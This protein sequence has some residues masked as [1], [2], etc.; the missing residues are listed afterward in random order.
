MPSHQVITLYKLILKEKK[1]LHSVR[2]GNKIWVLEPN[3]FKG[4]T[5]VAIFNLEAQR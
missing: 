3:G 5:A 1:K 2:T 4:K